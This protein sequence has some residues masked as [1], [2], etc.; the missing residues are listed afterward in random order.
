M[1]TPT[2]S[3]TAASRPTTVTPRCSTTPAGDWA[4][5]RRATLPVRDRRR[6]A[7]RRAARTRRTSRWRCWSGRCGARRPT[8]CFTPTPGCVASPRPAPRRRDRLADGARA[9]SGP[10]PSRSSRR[11][12]RRRSSC[13]TAC[14]PSRW[15]RSMASWQAQVRP[16]LE[17]DRRRAAGGRAEPRRPD[18]A[19]RR[20]RLAPRRVH[21]RLPGRGGCDVV[22]ESAVDAREARVWSELATIR[23]PEIP[24]IS[25]VE[26]GVIGSVVRRRSARRGR[27]AA[28]LR[29]LPGH[30]RHAGADHRARRRA[31]HG[32]RGRGRAQL[33]PALDERTDH[34][35]RAASGCG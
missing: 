5:T 20:L 9:R 24:A 29:R 32:G 30:R 18:A 31:R 25:L 27:A 17:P 2:A 21:D 16:V 33:R 6:G 8:T 1:T 28:D 14:C 22:T 7:P 10:M 15:R 34:A 12:T 4:F 13:A 35:G 23:D 26:L 19:H 3:P 11:S